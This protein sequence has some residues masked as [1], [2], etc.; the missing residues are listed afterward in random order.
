MAFFAIALVTGLAWKRDPKFGLMV[1]G[2][3]LMAGLNAR[4]QAFQ[5]PTRPTRYPNS[6]RR[7]GFLQTKVR[8]SLDDD[9][10]RLSFLD[11]C[12]TNDTRTL[13]LHAYTQGRVRASHILRDP[14]RSMASLQPPTVPILPIGGKAWATPSVCVDNPQLYGSAE[15]DS[16]AAVEARP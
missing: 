2:L 8:L 15:V 13:E 7:L 16:T 3:P 1:I 12:E 10:A 14:S 6:N 5:T 4:K 11:A 9:E